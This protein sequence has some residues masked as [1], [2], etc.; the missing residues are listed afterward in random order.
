MARGSLIGDAEIGL[1]A[2][3]EQNEAGVH[4]AVVRPV[5][6]RAIAR[7]LL[8]GFALV[9][10]FL[11]AAGLLGVRNISSIRST[12]A[13]LLNEQV[14]IQDLLDAVLKEQR[15][16]NAIYADFAKQPDEINEDQLVAQLEASDRDIEQLAAEAAGEPEQAL[17]QDLYRAVTHFSA[18]ARVI[19]SQDTSKRRP[20]RQLMDVHQTVLR[21]VDELVE[22]QTQRSVILKQRLEDLSTRLTMQSAALLG[23][24]LLMSLMCAVYAVRWT[25]R[26]IRQLEWQAGEL[27]R[28]SWQLL[29]KQESTARRFSHELHDEL[30]QSLT[31]MKANLAALAGASKEG[32]A[33]IEDCLQLADEALA[34]V[35]ELSQLLRPTILD[36]FGLAAGLKWLCDRFQQRTGIE[37]DFRCQGEER[38]A[39]ETETH[40]F[41]IAQEALTNVARHSGATRVAVALEKSGQKARLRVSDNGRGLDPAA[42]A[43]PGLGMVGMRA[44]ARSAGGELRI[45]PGKERGLEVVV[46]FPVESQSKEAVRQG[47]A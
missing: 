35:R 30:G 21:L 14:R 38:F 39:D 9:I 40:L 13:E 44:R 19:L 16:I 31:A 6:A 34:N 15:T 8:A 4:A 36:D 3:R 28:V 45:G 22:A 37:V 1:I 42:G 27:S 17:W 20:L 7:V 5:T 23:A 10:L 33:Q 24:S 2:A 32:R 43:G 25:L 26:L 47:A 46:E 18:E 11:L 29:E 12:T 41:R